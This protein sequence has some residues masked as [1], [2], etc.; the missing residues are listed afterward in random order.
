MTN[1]LSPADMASRFGRG[2]RFVRHALYTYSAEYLKRYFAGQGVPLELTDGFH[3][4]PGSLKAADILH[5]LLDDAAAYGCTV[6]TGCGVEEILSSDGAVCGVAAGGERFYAAHLL[7]ACGGRSYSALGGSLSGYKLVQKLG[8]SVVP[9]LPAMV[10]LQCREEWVKECAGISLPE[11]ESRIALPKEKFRCRGELLFTHTGISAFAVLDI[12]GRVAELLALHKSVPL[13]IDLMPQRS[14]NEWIQL[15]NSWQ[16]GSGNVSVSRLLSEDFP[17]RLVN[18]LCPQGAV[19]AAQF[20][21]SAR[22]EFIRKVTALELNI[23]ATDGWEKAMVTR[24][25]VAL[26]EVESKTLESRIVRRLYFAGEVLDVDG[27]CG[28]YNISWALASGF[29]VGNMMGRET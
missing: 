15:F 26:N 22:D 23:T 11:A 20:P 19:K 16:K 10:G 29:L 5:A 1:I 13:K 18:I 3:Y 7:V 28:G 17:R 8:H 14:E 6:K 9:L 21:A 24:G 2:A 12:S 25:G 4:F 27:P